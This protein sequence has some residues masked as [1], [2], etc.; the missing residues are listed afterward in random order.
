MWWWRFLVQ[1]DDKITRMSK[2]PISEGEFPTTAIFRVT[3]QETSLLCGEVIDWHHSAFQSSQAWLDFITLITLTYYMQLL[4]KRRNSRPD[5]S[6]P[7]RL[8][9]KSLTTPVSTHQLLPNSTVFKLN[10]DCLFWE[11]RSTWS[12]QPM[13]SSGTHTVIS[14][15]PC[16]RSI[17]VR[18]HTYTHAQTESLDFRGQ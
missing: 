10:V 12:W 7:K 4:H 2:R 8:V 11:K 17:H 9:V 1:I 14:V 3:S 5:L 18:T 13:H 16:S 15:S 6:A